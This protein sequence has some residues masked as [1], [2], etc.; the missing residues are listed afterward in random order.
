[1]TVEAA[2]FPTLELTMFK[3]FARGALHCLSLVAGIL[4]AN[5]YAQSYPDRPVRI[6]VPAAAGGGGDAVARVIGDGLAARWKQPVIVDARPGAGGT[7]GANLV[8]KAAPDGY[9][10]MLGYASLLTITPLVYQNL[11]YQPFEDFAAVSRIGSTPLLMAVHPSIQAKTVKD[12]ISIARARPGQLNYASSGNGTLS[13]LSAELFKSLANVNIVHVPYRGASPGYVATLGGQTTM[14]F[15][16]PSL[17]KPHIQSGQIQALGV[18]SL[19]RS[20][21]LPDV[22]TIAESGITGFEVGNWYAL[23]YPRGTP[24]QIIEKTNRDV[25]ALLREDAI[26]RQLLNLEVE[27]TGGTPAQLAELIK[28]DYT[29][30]KTMAGS[31]KL[32]A[33]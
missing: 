24:A 30:W 15:V 29:N 17:A 33:D 3:T 6:I 12:L 13:H 8:A 7:I 26:K 31:I 11:P 19:N 27:P 16:T 4:Y 9:T 21:A 23:F 28:R 2:T 32:T 1:M 25:N 22:P 14:I 20:S 5:A 18:T 10:M